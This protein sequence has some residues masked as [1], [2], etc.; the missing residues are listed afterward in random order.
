MGIDGEDES[1]MSD[2]HDCW[3]M[4]EGREVADDDSERVRLRML[5]TMASD[6]F[7]GD[8]LGR[9]D[10]ARDALL[11]KFSGSAPGSSSVDTNTAALA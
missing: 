11:G 3:E 9:Y 1:T 6:A 8:E 4:V 5:S 10:V 7:A 2:W